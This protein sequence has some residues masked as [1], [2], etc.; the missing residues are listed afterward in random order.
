MPELFHELG[1]DAVGIENIAGEV[2]GFP[3]LADGRQHNRIGFFAVD[4]RGNQVSC[5]Q[6]GAHYP[7]GDGLQ[8]AE[9]A[10]TRRQ[11]DR[12]SLG[13]VDRVNLRSADA[14][15]AFAPA[16]RPAGDAVDA[17]AP[18]QERPEERQGQIQAHPSQGRARIALDQQGVARR[19]DGKRNCAGRKEANRHTVHRISPGRSGCRLH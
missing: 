15:A 18:V 3:C 8:V 11:L 2:D 19:R 1:S 4:E 6:P 13:V 10:G 16:S 14:A 5:P 7:V 17:Q 12:L 9:V